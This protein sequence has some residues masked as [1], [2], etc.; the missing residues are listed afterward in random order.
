MQEAESNG[1]IS[2]LSTS[3]KSGLA[4]LCPWFP[5]APPGP[6]D[7]LLDHL[8]SDLPP[9]ERAVTLVNVY[10]THG[11]F[12]IRGLTP[13]QLQDEVLP[14]VYLRHLPPLEDHSDYSSPH[15]LALLYGVLAIGALLDPSLPPFNSEADGYADLAAAALGLQSPFHRPSSLTV[16]CLQV[17]YAFYNMRGGDIMD[18]SAAKETVWSLITLAAQ[19]AQL[20]ST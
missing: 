14:A 1:S 10:S 9:W 16:Q 5:F 7:T 12:I 18:S 6:T 13:S 3:S 8:R 11:S 17:I 4:A 15:A 20:V 19:V 2:P